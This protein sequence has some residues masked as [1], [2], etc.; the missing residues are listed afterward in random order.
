MKNLFLRLIAVFD[1]PEI[2]LEEK[3]RLQHQ[4]HND[5]LSRN[6]V[7]AEKIGNQLLILNR[8]IG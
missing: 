5:S 3:T 7:E 6:W 2:S 4:L 8:Q 1:K